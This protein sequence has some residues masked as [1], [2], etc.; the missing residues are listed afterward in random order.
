MENRA[1][2]AGA[3]ANERLTAVASAALLPLFVVVLAATPRAALRV[4]ADG[5]S[6]AALVREEW[7]ERGVGA[8]GIDL[9]AGAV[10]AGL[11]GAIVALAIAAPW[12]SPDAFS[13]GLGG[14]IIAATLLTALALIV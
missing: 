7:P 3:R 11:A 9:S 5:R 4:V 6:V 8:G 12:A 1:P 2:T 10:L 13:Q 14:P